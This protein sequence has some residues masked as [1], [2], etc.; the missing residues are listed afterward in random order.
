[1][2]LF[3]ICNFMFVCIYISC[4]EIDQSSL[5]NKQV[6]DRIHLLGSASSLSMFMLALKM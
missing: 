3:M 1:M 5:N 4:K 2:I 6:P